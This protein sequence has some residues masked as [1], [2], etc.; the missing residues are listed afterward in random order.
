[1]TRLLW[2]LFHLVVIVSVLL[3][4]ATCALWLVAQQA[5]RQ[6]HWHRVG[7]EGATVQDRTVSVGWDSEGVAVVVEDVR[8]V[9]GHPP[10]KWAVLTAVPVP[11]PPPSPGDL[12]R[13]RE[14]CEALRATPSDRLE[15]FIGGVQ[16]GYHD[17]ANGTLSTEITSAPGTSPF[18]TA[19]AARSPRIRTWGS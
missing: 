6:F 7:L 17:Y 16:V 13:A 10:S 4:A 14:Q 19:A 5:H 9:H 8:Y 11:A 2:R 18:A 3:L 12:R 1:M 15:T